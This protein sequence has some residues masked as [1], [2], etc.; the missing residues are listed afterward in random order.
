V[1]RADVKTLYARLRDDPRPTALQM[2]CVGRYQDTFCPVIPIAPGFYLK[3]DWIDH[4]GKGELRG[5]EMITDWIERFY[6]SPTEP[7]RLALAYSLDWPRN[8]M[9]TLKNLPPRAQLMEARGMKMILLE[10]PNLRRQAVD[11]FESLRESWI[12]ER[13]S[14]PYGIYPALIWGHLTLGER[15]RARELLSEFTPERTEF[16]LYE[17]ATRLRTQLAQE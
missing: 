14:K 17:A 16:D 2:L 5:K 4:V 6:T 13:G 1:N 12:A 15:G 10:G 8:P 3:G 7:E 11:L 9:P